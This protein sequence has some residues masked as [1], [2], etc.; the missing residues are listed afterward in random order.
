M[1]TILDAL[2]RAEAERE[3][4]VS[5]ALPLSPL[6]LPPASPPRRI[7]PL[8]WAAVGALAALLVLLLAWMLRG[9]GALPPAAAPAPAPAV[10]PSAAQAPALTPAS[11]PLPAPPALLQAAGARATP[12]PAPEPPQAASVPTAAATPPQRLPRL[13]EL[14]AATRQQLPVL[15]VGGAMHA[16]DARLRSL[17]VN[18]QLLREGDALAPNLVVERIGPRS[19]VL[20]WGS[21][22]FELPY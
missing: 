17:I 5:E 18:G 2:R 8:V 12:Q 15:Q 7:R 19:A 13:H 1:S 6:T 22:R 16:E 10:A 21:L 3:R 20:R 9:N 4:P 11:R 14:P